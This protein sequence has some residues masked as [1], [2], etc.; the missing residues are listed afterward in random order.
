MSPTYDRGDDRE[1]RGRGPLERHPVLG[2]ALITL[3]AAIALSMTF[4]I[5]FKDR[6]GNMVDSRVAVRLLDVAF[7]FALGALLILVVIPVVYG[8]RKNPGWLRRYLRYMR[9]TPGP[10]P[11]VTAQATGLSLLALPLLIIIAA[12]AAGVSAWDPGSLIRDDQ[13]TVF[14]LALVP[15]I[16]EELVF[17]G[18]I[19]RNLERHFDQWQAIVISAV[20]FGLFHLGN[21]WATDDGAAVIA[22]VIAATL[23]GLGWGYIVVG[24][25]SVLPAMLLH[26]T[27]DVVLDAGLFM[28][29]SASDAAV[30]P[31]YVSLVLLWPAL[32]VLA[33]RSASSGRQSV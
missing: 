5:D 31:V 1:L 20:L 30:A 13:W 22:G 4:M 25:G 29:P 26:Y 24:T 16:W 12:T 10:A 32:T 33:V 27:V 8:Y 17:R 21:L 19:M 7:R 15:G 18:V 14:L 9:V 11:V 28:D 23:L 2:S 6:I 3:L